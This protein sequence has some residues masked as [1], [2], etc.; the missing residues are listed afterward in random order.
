[1]EVKGLVVGADAE[2]TGVRRLLTGA[3]L[4]SV[5]RAVDMGAVELTGEQGE[6]LALHIQCAFRVLHED[7]VLLG[8]RDMTYVRGD[9]EAD[10]FDN[11]ATA[12][13]GRAALLS[14]VL[15]GARPKIESVLQNPAGAL[16]LK[17]TRGFSVEV[18]PD[19]SATEE[20]WRAFRRGGEHFG[21]PPSLVQEFAADARP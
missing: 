8:S 14:R 19:R 13:D 9:A 20:S 5:G 7:Q 2:L 16:T 15:G 12:C 10:A 1:M 3:V 18:F 17:A 4:R 21:F 6:D 11:F